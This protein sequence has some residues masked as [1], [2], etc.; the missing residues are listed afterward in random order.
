MTRLCDEDCQRRVGIV[1]TQVI[2]NPN[3][4]FQDEESV[5]ELE[6]GSCVLSYKTLNP[7]GKIIHIRPV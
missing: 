6:T 3:Y 2:L 5:K 1:K 7:V 4:S